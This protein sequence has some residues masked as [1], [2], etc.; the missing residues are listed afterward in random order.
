MICALEK[1]REQAYYKA[2]KKKKAQ[3]DKN[4][5]CHKNRQP[6]FY[7]QL[8]KETSTNTSEIKAQAIHRP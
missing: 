8:Q 4:M 3:L 2:Q 7:H 5:F 1:E 6:A